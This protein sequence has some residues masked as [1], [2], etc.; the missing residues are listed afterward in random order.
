MCLYYTKDAL[1]LCVTNAGKPACSG[2]GIPD[3]LKNRLR[4][5]VLRRVALVDVGGK[6]L[7]LPVPALDK[8]VYEPADARDEPPEPL[9]VEVGRVE[10]YLPCSA[11]RAAS[12]NAARIA[13]PV[14]S[15][16][17]F[18]ISEMSEV[19]VGSFSESCMVWLP[20]LFKLFKCYLRH[21][22]H[23]VVVD[24]YAYFIT[25]RIGKQTQVLAAL[26]VRIGERKR[27]DYVSTMFYAI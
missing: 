22:L 14:E 17:F 16:C 25:I 23:R 10:V 21:F 20:F 2:H 13:L 4:P 11:F 3:V 8:H 24:M 18:S 9:R 27:R 26:H 5:P 6:G 7:E 12:C 15:S 1:G 19:E